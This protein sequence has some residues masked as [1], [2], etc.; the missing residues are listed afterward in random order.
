[1]L[2]YIEIT[3]HYMWIFYIFTSFHSSFTNSYGYLG[4]HRCATF[5]CD[6]RHR[7][8]YLRCKSSSFAKYR[9]QSYTICMDKVGSDPTI[10]IFP[11]ESFSN[12]DSCHPT[13]CCDRLCMAIQRPAA[14]EIQTEIAYGLTKQQAMSTYLSNVKTEQNNTKMARR[15]M[16]SNI[17]M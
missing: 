15:D 2:G 11:S 16:R 6:N 1:M 7:F 8:Y 14:N 17:K 10:A 3:N 4:V 5:F 9:A 12:I 13:G